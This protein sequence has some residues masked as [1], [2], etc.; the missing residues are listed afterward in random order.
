MQDGQLGRQESAENSMIGW[1][2]NWQRERLKTNS[3][4]CWNQKILSLRICKQYVNFNI[5][6][7]WSLEWQ[8]S[9]CYNDMIAIQQ[10]IQK[11]FTG[12]RA[13]QV[14]YITMYFPNVCEKNDYYH[15]SNL[16]LTTNKLL[17]APTSSEK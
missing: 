8:N 1:R 15:C 7:I 11:A 2:R 16:E 9:H 12:K 5:E 17:A 10:C 6:Y 14:A 4:N 3:Y 13:G